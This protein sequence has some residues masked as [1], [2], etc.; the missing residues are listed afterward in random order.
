MKQRPSRTLHVLILAALCG[1][2]VASCAL[3]LRGPSDGSSNLRAAAPLPAW[4]IAQVEFGRNTRFAQCLPPACPTLTPKTLAIAEQPTLPRPIDAAASLDAGEALVNT[5]PVMPM[6]PRTAGASP[7]PEPLT[8]QVIVHF[9]FGTA[10]LTPSAQAELDRAA[11]RFA[12]AQRVAISGRTDNVGSQVVNEALAEARA[13]AVRGHLRLRFPQLSA[14]ATTEAK[15]ACCYA[16]P[17][18]SERGRALNRRVEVVFERD[19][20]DL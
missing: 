18:D 11:N 5:S 8:T 1:G 20:P 4:R 9:P 15:G 17:N 13:S 6:P 3:P 19:A 7:R 12:S 10:S 14:A 16:A 2:L